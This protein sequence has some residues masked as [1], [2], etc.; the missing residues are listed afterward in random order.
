MD[1][2]HFALNVPDARAAADWYVQ[3]LGFSVV[4]A[5]EGPPHTRFLADGTGRTVLE[6][7]SNPAAAIPDYAKQHWL[8]VHFAVVSTD[9]AADRA[10]LEKA[11]ATLATIDKLPDG[12]QV[13]T[14]RD[15]WGVC[16]QLCQRAQPL[17]R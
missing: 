4:R 6:I 17:P 14:M 8:V 12:S 1:F 5:V 9:A 15:P 3:H 10:R 7:Y 2:E 11:G 13:I 16:V